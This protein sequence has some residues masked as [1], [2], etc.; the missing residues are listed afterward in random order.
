[1]GLLIL[2]LTALYYVL[3]IYFFILIAFVLLSW[4]PD[5]KQ[6]RFYY[7]LHVLANPYMRLFRGIIVIGAFDFTPIVGFMLYSFGLSAFDQLI[8][9]L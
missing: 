3:Q 5:I 2:A 8:Q 9:S 1:M 4:V 6:T 7:L